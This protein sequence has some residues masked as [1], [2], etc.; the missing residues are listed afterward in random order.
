MTR[1][2]GAALAAAFASGLWFAPEALAQ[3]LK[4]EIKFA[5]S[6]EKRKPVD[7]GTSFTPGKLY[8]WNHVTGGTGKF[9]IYHIWYVNGRKVRKQGITVKGKRW[10]TWSYYKVRRGNWKVEVQDEA[11]KVIGAGEF[12]VDR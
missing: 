7:P 9:K 12:T 10:T 4:V 2:I 6:L 8:C 1:I 11:G 3:D 5:R